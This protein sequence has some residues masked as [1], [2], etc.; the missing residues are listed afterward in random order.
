MRSVV[1]VSPPRGVVML[2]AIFVSL[3]S[4]PVMRP[5]AAQ[6]SGAATETLPA[7]DVISTR[8]GTRSSSSRGGNTVS[9][10]PSS[11]GRPNRGVPTPLFFLAF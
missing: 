4:S 7:I 2:V 6:D 1:F 10:S 5:A 9:P 8:I 11:S 3:F